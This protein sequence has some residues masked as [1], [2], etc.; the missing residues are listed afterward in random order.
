[1]LC[2]VD[3]AGVVTSYDVRWPQQD[4]VW[5][6][7]ICAM[8]V[9][10]S[11]RTAMLGLV[12]QTKYLPSLVEVLRPWAAPSGS[13]LMSLHHAAPSLSPSPACGHGH[14]SAACE[15][16]WLPPMYRGLLESVWAVYHHGPANMPGMT[17]E[18]LQGHGS[19][20]CGRRSVP[21][22]HA[23]MTGR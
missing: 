2:R 7:E 22:M 6:L 18:L 17:T 3:T 16:V 12:Q 14:G 15:H 11:M 23:C 4:V 20:V 21:N 13:G 5:P 9:S 8:L 19:M 10:D 1:M